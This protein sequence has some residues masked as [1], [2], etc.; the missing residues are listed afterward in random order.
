MWVADAYMILSEG[1]LEPDWHKIAA[2]STSDSDAP[3]N[4]STDSTNRAWDG[5]SASPV[6]VF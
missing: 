1:T 3:G 4:C 2:A 5:G 6:T